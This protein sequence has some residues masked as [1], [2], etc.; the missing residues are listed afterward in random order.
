MGIVITTVLFMIMISINQDSGPPQQAVSQDDQSRTVADFE[1]E[2]QLGLNTESGQTGQ[3]E[4][5]Q[6]ADTPDAQ[7]EENDPANA[8][9]TQP[10]ANEKANASDTQP[11]ANEKANANDKKPQSGKA[12]KVRFIISGGEYSDVICQKLE[13]VGLIDDAE[14]YN[15]FLV[16]E[17]Y[18]NF[19]NPGVYDIPKDATYEEIAVLFTTKVEEE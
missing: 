9:D 7:P 3:P 12:G 10:E 4:D 2:A 17:N 14:A 18:D 8:P 6:P 16:E 13:E 15:N 11:E 5:G 19:I 1:N